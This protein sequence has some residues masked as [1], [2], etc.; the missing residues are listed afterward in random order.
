MGAPRVPHGP[1]DGTVPCMRSCA[2]ILAVVVSASLLTGC[3][4]QYEYA[5]SAPPVERTVALIESDPRVAAAL[6]SGVSVSLAIARTFERDYANARIRGQDR[7]RLLTMTRGAR[8]EATLDLSAQNIDSQGW[9]GTFSLTTPGRRVLR[10]GNYVTE[11]GGE[12][13]SGTFAPDGT[14]IVAAKQ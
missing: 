11:G 4:A 13:L 1:L 2:A 5:S 3:P 12:I 10:D 8:G 9:A 7:V 14:P 6:G